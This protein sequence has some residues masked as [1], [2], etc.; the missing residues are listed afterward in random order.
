MF[1]ALS[2]NYQHLKKNEICIL[3][4]IV[5]ELKNGIEILVGRVII[6]LYVSSVVYQKKE[7]FLF[8]IERSH[9]L[10]WNSI[11]ESNKWIKGTLY[12]IG[13]RYTS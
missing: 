7:C 2:Q 11:L 13:N 4:Q 6:P 10:P 1:C 5:H 3:K 8:A 9:H 12:T